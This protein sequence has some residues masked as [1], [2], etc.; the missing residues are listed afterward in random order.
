MAQSLFKT[1]KKNQP[2][3]Q[4][5]ILAPA[6]TFSLL[7]RMPEGACAVEMPLGHGHIGVIDF[8]GSL[9]LNNWYEIA[10]VK[11]SALGDIIH[12]MVAIQ[13][14]KAEIENIEIDWIMEER[15]A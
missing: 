3:C 14:I 12:T 6:G 5:D 2:E 11:P 15:F 13:F 8:N 1:L 9:C 7:D 4:I 10:I